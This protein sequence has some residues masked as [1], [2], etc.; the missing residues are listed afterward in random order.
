MGCECGLCGLVCCVAFDCLDFVLL[1]WWVL[2][3]LVDLVV[4]VV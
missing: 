2:C 1:L 3:W 4:G